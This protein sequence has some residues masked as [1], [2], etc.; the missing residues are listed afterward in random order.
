MLKLMAAE[1]NLSCNIL[2]LKAELLFNPAQFLLTQTD[3]D[4]VHGH[5][6]FM[7]SCNG[8]VQAIDKLLH[9]AKE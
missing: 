8:K 2:L 9:N 3:T 5:H 7:Q 4:T 6:T 1:L